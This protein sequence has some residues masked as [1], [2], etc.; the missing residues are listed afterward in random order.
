MIRV[1][2]VFVVKHCGKFK[3]RLLADGHLTKEPNKTIYSGVVSLRNLKLA[4]FLAELNYLQL[5][6][7]DVGNV[8]LQALTKE[9]STLWLEQ[10]LKSY[11]DMFLLCTKHSI[12]Q[13]LEKHVGMTGLLTVFN[14][15]TSNLQKQI[16]TYG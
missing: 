1:H 5:W 15:W 7:A 12:A 11:K 3:V 13:D 6:G 2:F 4:M 14:R 9:K 8:Y 10:N 16:L